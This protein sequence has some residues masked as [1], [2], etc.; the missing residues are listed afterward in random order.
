MFELLDTVVLPL[1]EDLNC[2]RSLT[3]AILWRN[4]EARQLVELSTVRSH[5]Q[6]AHD[7]FC[8]AQATD[9]IR[10]CEDLPTGVDRA[11]AAR[12]TFIACE[13]QN[14]RTN[15][16]LSPYLNG[17]PFEDSSQVRCGDFLREVAQLVRSILGP[18]PHSL[19]GRFGPGSTVENN[20]GLTTI[21]DKLTD[22]LMGT[23]AALSLLR[24]VEPYG[25]IHGTIDRLRPTK[26]VRGNRFFTV[27]KDGLTDRGC[28]QEPGA[29]VYLQL[30][31]GGEIRSRL[32]TWGL[33]LKTAQP[34]HKQAA[35]VGSREETLVT[36]DLKNASNTISRNF[37]KLCLAASPTWYALLSATRSP[38]VELEGKVRFLEMFS[39]MGNGFTFELETLLFAAVVKTAARWAG[40]E[41]RPGKDLLVYGDDIICPPG[42]AEVVISALRF[43]G[44]ETNPKKTCTEG[45]FRESCGGD[46]WLGV[47]VST[48]K[49]TKVPAAP[50]EWIVLANGLWRV[51][52]DHPGAMHQLRRARNHVLSN[53]PNRIRHLRGPQTLGDVVVHDDPSKW[54]VTV[55]NGIRFVRAWVAIPAVL[56]WYHW[57]PDTI[58]AAALY[59]CA[60]EGVTPRARGHLVVSGY[61][62]QLVAIH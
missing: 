35:C 45:P 20:R 62:Q 49:L 46:Y 34:R 19:C 27:P 53:I 39:S 6:T 4:R 43:C 9:F 40:R 5:Y 61:R 12:Q 58:L 30:A 31:L 44:F 25:R 11:L 14:T 41:L 26:E 56:P 13:E 10:K 2:P 17:G 33:D 21:P 55:T 51:G 18:V 23:P 3:V 60:A 50:E 7:Y 29:N 16:R 47:N 42:V 48:F 57:K 38:T 59:G 54:Q 15:A 52:H 22:I 24:E 37:V 36:I 32:K 1:M 8:A 28:G